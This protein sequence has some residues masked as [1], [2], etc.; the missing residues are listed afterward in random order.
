MAFLKNESLVQKKK[1]L[2]FFIVFKQVISFIVCLFFFFAL[3]GDIYFSLY[4]KIHIL[5]RGDVLLY[6]F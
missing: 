4:T 3:S 6:F 2:L 1:N 5:K